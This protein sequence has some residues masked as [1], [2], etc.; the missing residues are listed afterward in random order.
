M[1]TKSLSSEIAENITE[2]KKLKEKNPSAELSNRLQDMFDALHQAQ[3]KEWEEQV[4]KYKEAKDALDKAKQAAQNA[5]NDLAKTAQ[6][7]DKSASAFKAVLAALAF[8]L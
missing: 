7:I 5:I 3:E 1:A 8:A 2:L 4:V 6:A